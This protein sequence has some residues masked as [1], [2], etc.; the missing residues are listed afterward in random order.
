MKLNTKTMFY[1]AFYLNGTLSRSGREILIHILYRQL[2][3]NIQDLVGHSFHIVYLKDTRCG[4][5]TQLGPNFGQIFG[6]CVL[7]FSITKTMLFNGHLT[8]VGI[9]MYNC[10]SFSNLSVFFHIVCFWY[11]FILRLPLYVHFNLWLHFCK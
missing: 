10:I 1:T 9:I 5:T 3:Q 4:Q 8:H 7:R 6:S 11:Y 2:L